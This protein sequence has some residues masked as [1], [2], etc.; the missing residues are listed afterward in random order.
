MSQSVK[1]NEV[2][3][4]AVPCVNIPKSDNSGNA[5]FY[6]TSSGDI[7]AT[8]VRSGKK[9]WANGTEITGSVTGRT[10]SDVTASGKTVTIP[11][12]IYDTQAQKS[13]AD[14]AVTPTL[15]AVGDE[16]GDTVS[17]YEITL[18]PKATVN[19]AGYVSTISD[20]SAVTKYIQVEDKTVTPSD[21]SQDITPTSGKLMKKVTV[22]AV[23]LTGD[24]IAGN[25][26]SGKTF[27]SSNLTKLTGTL[28]VP[29]VSQD[30]TTKV[31]TIS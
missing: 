5:S 16:I 1:I 6:D 11:A 13:V 27:Y 23:S 2:T 26:V 20:G 17:D 3:Y 18:T 25:V 10:A 21:S 15:T 24:A 19:T 7:A 22:A 9:G 29:S 12:G 31:L 28:N 8:D 4:S 14:G 30:G